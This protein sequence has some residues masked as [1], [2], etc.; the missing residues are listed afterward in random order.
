MGMSVAVWLIAGIW[1]LGPPNY[2]TSGVWF[3][4]PLAWQVIFITGLLTGVAMKD[5]AALCSS[6]PLATGSDW[7]LPC[8]CGAVG[9]VSGCIQGHWPYLVAGQR[10]LSFALEHDRV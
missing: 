7:D 1:R 8:L 4:N 10:N 6:P 5:W 3:F 9:A 2:P